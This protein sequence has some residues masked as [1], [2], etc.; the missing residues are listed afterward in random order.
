V[1]NTQGG[2]LD[3]TGSSGTP[4]DTVVTDLPAAFSAGAP[5]ANGLPPNQSPIFLLTGL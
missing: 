1:I 4:A 3:N 5:E 2:N